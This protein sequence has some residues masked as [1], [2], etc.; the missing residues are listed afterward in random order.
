MWRSSELGQVYR[1]HLYYTLLVDESLIFSPRTGIDAPYSISWIRVTQ[2][3]P[4]GIHALNALLE[5]LSFAN[6]MSHS[7][8]RFQILSLL[9]LCGILMQA[10]LYLVLKPRWHDE[11]MKLGYLPY[12]VVKERLIEWIEVCGQFNYCRLQPKYRSADP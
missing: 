6:V 3:N 4:G 12:L 5:L 10:I 9:S 11:V 7:G 1:R 2:Y 8:N